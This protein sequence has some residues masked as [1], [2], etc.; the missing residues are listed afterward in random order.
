MLLTKQK[1]A[2][3]MECGRLEPY[4]NKEEILKLCRSA[5][6][7]GLGVAYANL[8]YLSLVGRA[9]AGSRT[10]LGI[11]IAFPFG[12]TSPEMKVLEARQALE[13]GA[14]E[15]D[16]V[17]NVQRFKS[18]E[19]SYVEDDIR[20]VVEAVGELTT[21]V[22]IE[23]C[24]LAK[25]EIVKAA[26]LVKEAGASYVKTSTGYGTY[27]A[28]LVDVQLIRENVDIGI[29]AAGDITDLYTCMAMIRAGATTIGANPEDAET[30][31]NEFEAKYG[32]QVEIQVAQVGER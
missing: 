7:L 8:S 29:K 24:F 6:A 16:M 27:C 28:R 31:L 14:V 3:M 15:F 2:G 11:P 21:K 13:E 20:G 25:A 17:M 30:I 12:A 26:Q 9:I 19:F 1:L 23:T 22:I 4:S 32:E 5:R 10:R 18:G